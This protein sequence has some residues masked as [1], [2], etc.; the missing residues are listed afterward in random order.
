VVAISAFDLA[1]AKYT[2]LS[3][4]R[5][6]VTLDEGQLSTI[7]SANSNGHLVSG[8]RQLV[9]QIER[10]VTALTDLKPDVPDSPTKQPFRQCD[11]AVYISR[12]SQSRW[13][14]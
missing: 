5:A 13:N 14:P 8:A 10:Q 3:K 9:L 1:I 7:L 6:K 12:V 2:T 11:E 4:R